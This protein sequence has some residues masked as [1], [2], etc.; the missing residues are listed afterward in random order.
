MKSFIS[1][2]LLFT[3]SLSNCGFL[4]NLK[5]FNQSPLSSDSS[6]IINTIDSDFF[7]NSLIPGKDSTD[8]LKKIIEALVIILPK[9]R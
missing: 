7:S 9:F 8:K 1:V 3:L 6:N 5:E 2:I 4:K